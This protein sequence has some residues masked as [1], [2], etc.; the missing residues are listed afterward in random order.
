MT[1]NNVVE[2]PNRMGDRTPVPQSEEERIKNIKS[3]QTRM[4]LDTSIEL[5]YQLFDEIQARGIDISVSPDIEQDMLMVCESIK[6]TMLRACGIQ[7]PLHKV[8]QETIQYPDSQR[9]KDV[10]VSLRETIDNDPLQ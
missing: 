2:F 4:V 5:S 3:Y 8:T 10:W 6:A 1:S 9:F 7:H